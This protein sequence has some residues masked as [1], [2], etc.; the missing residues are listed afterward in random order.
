MSLFRCLA[1]AVFLAAVCPTVA[2]SNSPSASSTVNIYAPRQP[3]VAMATMREPSTGLDFSLPQAWQRA[4]DSEED[5]VLKIGGSTSGHFGEL[6]ISKFKDKIEIPA[7]K[8]LIQSGFEQAFPGTKKLEE[9][10]VRFGNR[11]QFIGS[12][13]HLT[14][15]MGE[16]IYRDR[17]VFLI[18][19]GHLST[20]SLLCLAS[21]SSQ[22]QPLFDQILA[23]MH[24][25]QSTTER[26]SNPSSPKLNAL[27]TW[28]FS[29]YTDKTGT[30]AI[31]YPAGWKV[32]AADPSKENEAKFTGTNTKELGGE[33]VVTKIDRSPEFT[34]EKFNETYANT[35][36]KPLKD[37]HK[38]STHRTTF[39]ISRL[40]G[41][42]EYSTFSAEGHPGRQTVVFFSDNHHHHCVAL[43]TMLWSELEA[44]ELF[45]RILSS[46]KITE[47]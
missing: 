3:S 47:Q 6:K 40:D 1:M 22:M 44:R 25:G 23:S 14:F 34:L 39:G 37:Y 7:A 13:M 19:D 12:E 46:I 26:S 30:M 42:I 5:Q 18:L 38:Q 2:K 35:F 45:N 31:D 21:D 9:R 33:L 29:R 8:L 41:I 32:E 4:T 15:K 16:A 10:T 36:L 24:S 11:S 27:Q 28:K 43:T 17:I 20:L